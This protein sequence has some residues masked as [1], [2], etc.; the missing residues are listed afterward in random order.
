MGEN[1][2]SQQ[3]ATEPRRAL[4]ARAEAAWEDQSG[5][6]HVSAVMIEDTSRGGAGIKLKQAIDVGTKVKIKW[7]KEEFFGI[8]R[9]CRRL[10]YDYII[11][12]QRIGIDGK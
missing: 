1:R 2:N 12:V 6:L 8:V 10:G 4:I 7:P 11:G 5:V 3:R 9:H